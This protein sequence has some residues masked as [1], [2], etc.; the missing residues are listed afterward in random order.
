MLKDYIY[1]FLMVLLTVTG[2]LI[3]KKAA[4]SFR[5]GKKIISRNNSRFIGYVA[6]GTIV[7]LF[8]PLFYILALRKVPLGIAFSFTSL[9]Y[10]FVIIGSSLFF[11]EK[12]TYRRMFGVALIVA[13]IILFGFS[14]QT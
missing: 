6:A 4:M 9:N 8:A 5:S 3:I 7:T 11:K 13:G 2:Q 10:V 1:I 12:V 14:Y